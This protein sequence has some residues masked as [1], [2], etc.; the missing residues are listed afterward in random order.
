MFMKKNILFLT[1]ILL[2]L[3]CSGLRSAAHHPAQYPNFDEDSREFAQRLLEARALAPYDNL[4][5]DAIHDIMRMRMYISDKTELLNAYIHVSTEKPGTPKRKV[6]PI[7]AEFPTLVNDFISLAFLALIKDSEK[8]IEFLNRD[9]FLP[10]LISFVQSIPVLAVQTG[11]L[12][13]ISDLVAAMDQPASA[14]RPLRQ[15]AIYHAFDQRLQDILL[16]IDKL[17]NAGFSHI[18]IS[19]IQICTPATLDNKTPWFLAYQPLGYRIGNRYGNITDLLHLIAKAKSIGIGIIADVAL[20]WLAPIL[21]GNGG[22]NGRE[23]DAWNRAFS[24]G[25]I[26]DRLSIYQQLRDDNFAQFESSKD[27]LHRRPHQSDQ[28]NTWA[29]LASTNDWLSQY[30]P[31]L[32]LKS[33]YIQGRH[34]EFLQ[35]LMKMGVIG[36]RFDALRHFPYDCA[37]L[38]YEKIKMLVPEVIAYGECVWF[39]PFAAEPNAKANYLAEY[40]K[41]VEATR[42]RTM[43]FILATHLRGAF[44][45]DGNLRDLVALKT[46]GNPNSITFAQNHDTIEKENG[47]SDA[48][49]MLLC[50][51]EYWRNHPQNNEDRLLANA[52]LIA[53]SEGLPL[54]LRDDVW[55]KDGNVNHLLAIAFTFRNAMIDMLGTRSEVVDLQVITITTESMGWG[56][57]K[58][59]KINYSNDNN[60]IGLRVMNGQ[61]DVIGF[62][63]INK[64]GSTLYVKA[65]NLNLAQCF[66][67]AVQGQQ[68]E[69][70]VNPNAGRRIANKNLLP[71]YTPITADVPGTIIT[72]PARTV[73]FYIKTSPNAP[74]SN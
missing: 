27:I 15:V 51:D 1:V 56:E 10:Q 41:I 57:K 55:T 69:R 32:N 36:C 28:D 53:R 2:L 43:D 12:N 21:Q 31:A 65:D 63:I 14:P 48:R 62:A 44:C 74:D 19:P 45:M 64:S 11:L 26:D 67:V 71:P 72:I 29:R 20:R 50:A 13:E 22:D 34:I 52:F 25:S 59:S 3:H 58:Q 4:L 47:G 73:A 5:Y 54:I 9:A 66:Y 42:M 17:A 8:F 70:S 46:N 18:Q 7:D 6:K 39:D 24:G 33:E 40:R 60:L 61:N 23:V 68:S 35:T 49:G 30:M 16:Q 38:Y 37:K